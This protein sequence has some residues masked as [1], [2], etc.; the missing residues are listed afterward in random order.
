MEKENKVRM[1][2]TDCLYTKI[3]DRIKSDP[4]NTR[5]IISD[6]CPKC[7]QEGITLRYFDFNLKER[8]AKWEEER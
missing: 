2:C 7:S 3:L 5:F 1:I 8:F 6:G 4:P